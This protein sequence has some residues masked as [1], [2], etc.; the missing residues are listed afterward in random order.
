MQFQRE[1]QIRGDHRR[2]S[3][4]KDIAGIENRNFD[5][6]LL[7]YVE[8]QE[9]AG[10]SDSNKKLIDGNGDIEMNQPQNYS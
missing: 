5:A 2:E 3:S 8:S 6:N 1:D 9:S 4:F 10:K 7:G